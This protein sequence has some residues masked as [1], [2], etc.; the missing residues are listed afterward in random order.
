MLTQI[1]MNPI[2]QDEARTYVAPPPQMPQAD[3][4]DSA[5][6]QFAGRIQGSLENMTIPIGV[7]FDTT[8]RHP[9][10][11]AEMLWL[12]AVVGEYSVTID[13]LSHVAQSFGSTVQ[14]LTQRS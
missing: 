12:Q 14:S 8:R 2:Q 6:A 7:L 3:G 10:S 9:L 13:T 5:I 4:A 11:T 1:A